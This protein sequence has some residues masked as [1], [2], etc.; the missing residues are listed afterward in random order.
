[1]DWQT[2][3]IL[4]LLLLIVPFILSLY[5]MSK[6]KGTFAK[7]SKVRSQKGVTG[8]EVAR[9][10]LQNAGITDV[11]VQQVPGSL[12]DH[13][14]PRTKTIRLSEPVFGKASISAVGVAAHEAGH[15]IQH[16]VGYAPLNFRSALVPLASF[17]SRAAIPLILLGAF[18]SIPSLIPV[19]IVLFSG[20]VLFQFVTLPVEFN[21]SGR[22]MEM[23]ESSGLLSYDETDSARKV[24][25]AA[26][27]TYVA[28][29][30][31][32]VA[33]LLRLLLIYGRRR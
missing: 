23:V 13:Y 4:Q 11:V 2:V 21:A 20:A 27:L 12:T 14:D 31:V 17:G 7:Y 30:C 19:G 10:I 18:M 3:Q 33:Q 32:A 15:A 26:A 1:M 5:A 8:A 28:A 24:L 16:N 29:A 25:N 6:V 9:Q 22:A